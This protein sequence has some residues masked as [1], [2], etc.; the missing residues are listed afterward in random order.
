MAPFVIT[1]VACCSGLQV[2]EPFPAFLLAVREP[3][4]GRAGVMSST[5]Q[6]T[7]YSRLCN[8]SNKQ[9]GVGRISAALR[10]F[11]PWCAAG[12]AARLQR[13]RDALRS[14]FSVCS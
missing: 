9:A 12:L 10:L 3:G 14:W 6:I 5:K 2:L 13:A 4:R 11:Q 1:F 8:V 7:A